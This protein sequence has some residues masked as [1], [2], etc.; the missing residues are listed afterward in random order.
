MAFVP[1]EPETQTVFHFFPKLWPTLQREFEID[2]ACAALDVFG[3]VSRERITTKPFAESAGGRSLRGHASHLDNARC[4]A[5]TI[6]GSRL[7]VGYS[8]VGQRPVAAQ[9][10]VVVEYDMPL[11]RRGSR[12]RIERRHHLSSPCVSVD[13]IFERDGR[14]L[15][16]RERQ[17]I[18][19]VAQDD[20]CQVSGRRDL[21][22]RH[23]INA[24]NPRTTNQVRWRIQDLPVTG[25]EFAV[26][27]PADV[28]LRLRTQR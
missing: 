9:G 25:D 22:L 5:E 21:W 19:S 4:D 28:Y 24:Q 16:V 6:L 14:Q 8:E 18:A 7:I 20:H 13:P 11:E 2:A 1:G 10:A 12:I 23:R 17:V 3:L 27:Q 26:G 15:D